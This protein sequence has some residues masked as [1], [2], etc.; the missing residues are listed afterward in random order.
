MKKLMGL[1]I[2][3]L[4]ALVFNA[5]RADGFNWLVTCKE[6]DEYGRIHIWLGYESSQ[7]LPD[8]YFMYSGSGPGFYM[9][10]PLAGRYDMA[11]ETIFVAEN[12]LTISLEPEGV[13]ITVTEDTEAPPCD[14][15]PPEE[16]PILDDQGVVNNPLYND[17]A[18]TCYDPGQVCASPED[19]TAGYYLIR[20]QYGML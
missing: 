7:D 3:L 10:E 12:Y 13:S 9:D 17:R 4:L 6:V 16:P 15:P 2:V 18:N 1:S 20:K 14:A 5:V 8:S 11:I 19:W